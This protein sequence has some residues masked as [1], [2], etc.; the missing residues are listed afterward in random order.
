[1]Q[2]CGGA[3]LVREVHLVVTFRH[4]RWWA[5]CTK[6]GSSGH[7]CPNP[8]PHPQKRE[9]L[10]GVSRYWYPQPAFLP[11]GNLQFSFEY[12]LLYF[13]ENNRINS[14]TSSVRILEL[15][16][17]LSYYGQGNWGRGS[18][19]GSP[20][21]HSWRTQHSCPIPCCPTEDLTFAGK[22]FPH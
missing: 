3:H 6:I 21:S 10:K 11:V 13:L 17:A 5:L 12:A 16:G 22:C 18:L 14:V 2:C 9:I 20:I 7:T 19:L 15:E 4:P 1:M 8:A